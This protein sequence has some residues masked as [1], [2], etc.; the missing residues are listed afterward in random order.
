MQ[1]N[2]SKL[3]FL[4]SWLSV[5]IAIIV[6]LLIGLAVVAFNSSGRKET[7]GGDM[8]SFVVKRGPLRISVTESGTIKARDQVILKSE[9]EGR[10]SIPT[11]VPEGD[12]VKKG[13]LLVELDASGLLDN[14]ID[15]YQV[16]F[17]HKLQQ[18]NNHQH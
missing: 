8:P 7:I 14:K 5:S 6:L 2:K 13:Q 18:Y 16:H 12:R 1:A 9:V 4:R 15:H 17:Q 11:L 10:T 3:N